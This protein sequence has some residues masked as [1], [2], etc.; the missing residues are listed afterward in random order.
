MAL[1]GNASG[2]SISTGS[3]ARVLAADT[4]NVGGGIDSDNGVLHVEGL[5]TQGGVGSGTQGIAIGTNAGGGNTGSTRSVYI[6]AG[7]GSTITT[8]DNYVSQEQFLLLH[9]S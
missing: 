5:I 8:G 4:L 2:S 3:F 1:L 7:A 9:L 6:G